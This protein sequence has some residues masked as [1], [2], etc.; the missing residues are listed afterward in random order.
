MSE[1]EHIA[2]PPELELGV[3][4]HY[5]GGLYEVMTL[6]CDEK[7]HEWC[8]VYKALYDT[9]ENPSVWIRTYEDF[10][11]QVAVDGIIKKRFEKVSSSEAQT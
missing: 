5:K 7:T 9:G 1:H 6:A 3:Y 11:Q 8:V 2:P 10:T 4:R